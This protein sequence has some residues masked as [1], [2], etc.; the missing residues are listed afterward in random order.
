MYYKFERI[1]VSERVAIPKKDLFIGFFLAQAFDV[2]FACILTHFLFPF[3]NVFMTDGVTSFLGKLGLGQNFAL[4]VFNSIFVIA[5]DLLLLFLYLFNGTFSIILDFLDI[6]LNLLRKKI[7]KKTTKEDD[8]SSKKSIGFDSTHRS[9]LHYLI[10]ATIISVLIG[11]WL[12][13]YYLWIF[14]FEHLVHYSIGTSGS[15]SLWPLKGFLW[16]RKENGIW[17]EFKLF[18]QT[19]SPIVEGTRWTYEFY[20]KPTNESIFGLIIFLFGFIL[21]VADSFGQSS[22]IVLCFISYLCIF[23]LFIIIKTYLKYKG[24]NF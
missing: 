5:L 14:V 17:Y 18:S 24:T 15:V 10:P 6:P 23:S 1:K 22:P 19:E 3:S 12:R 8:S 21:L 20:L 4:Y 16:L 2:G 7:F 11:L 9:L 13:H